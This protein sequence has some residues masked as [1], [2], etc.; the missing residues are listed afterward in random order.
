MFIR[1]ANSAPFSSQASRGVGE[2]SVRGERE[3][4]GL[5][6]Q[7][8][9]GFKMVEGCQ[10]YRWLLLPRWCQSEVERWAVLRNW[11]HTIQQRLLELLRTTTAKNL[12]L[13]KWCRTYRH[14]LHSYTD[15][16]CISFKIDILLSSTLPNHGITLNDVSEDAIDKFFI[17]W[18]NA[19]IKKTTSLNSFRSCE[20][21]H[22][23]FSPWWLYEC[24]EIRSTATW[25]THLEHHYLSARVGF[26]Q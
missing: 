25:Q 19:Q 8:Q 11:V 4:A 3:R 7:Q 5:W 21:V 13:W 2:V 15:S 24:T 6:L 1:K 9:C 10:I 23:F 14:T 16:P 22:S 12:S 26:K 17:C 18:L 20:S